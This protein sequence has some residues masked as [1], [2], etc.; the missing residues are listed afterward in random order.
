MGGQG[1][2]L[3]GAMYW[4]SHSM[5]CLT[6]QLIVRTYSTVGWPD[7]GPLA[8]KSSAPMNKYH[9]KSNMLIKYTEIPT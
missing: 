1:Q 4:E 8:D 2:S 7:E 5:N 3:P 6:G 9:L